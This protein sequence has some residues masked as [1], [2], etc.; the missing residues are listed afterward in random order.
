M[1]NST[2]THTFHKGDKV[3]VAI[4]VGYGDD[5]VVFHNN[6]PLKKDVSGPVVKRRIEG[7]DFDLVQATETSAILVG[8]P[9]WEKNAYEL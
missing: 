7:H 9:P 2:K 5:D 8:K 3:T 6:V 4:S 1:P